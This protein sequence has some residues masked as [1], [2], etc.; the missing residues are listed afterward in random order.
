MGTQI[1]LVMIMQLLDF[2]S[3]FALIAVAGLCNTTD[4]L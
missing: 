3:V 2:V 4:N 1:F